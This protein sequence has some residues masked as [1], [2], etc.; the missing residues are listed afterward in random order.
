MKF[1]QNLTSVAGTLAI[2]G[3]LVLVGLGTA[4]ASDQKIHSAFSHRQ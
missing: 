4:Q 1:I 2:L 3:A